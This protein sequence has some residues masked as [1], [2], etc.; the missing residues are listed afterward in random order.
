MIRFYRTQENS[1]IARVR[2]LKTQTAP[3][4]VCRRSNAVGNFG[5]GDKSIADR[6]TE[7]TKSRDSRRDSAPLRLPDERRTVIIES[8]AHDGVKACYGLA[9]W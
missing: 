8:S 2:D 9:H 6:N 1:R 3:A 7:Q 5:R 4:I